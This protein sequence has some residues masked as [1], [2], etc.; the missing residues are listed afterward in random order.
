MLTEK[1]K[2]YAFYII[3]LFLNPRL[4]LLP[5]QGIY[6]PVYIQFEWLKKYDI[7]TV[8]DV[9]AYHGHVSKSLSYLFPQAKIYAFE[10]VAENYKILTKTLSGKNLALNQIALSGGV[11]KSTFYKNKYAP[12]SSMLPM[13]EKYKV[14]YPFLATATKT[15]VKT[16][17]LDSYFEKI[18]LQKKI[19]LKIDTQGT[20]YLILRGGEKILKNVFIIHIETSFDAMYKNQGTFKDITEYLTKLGFNYMGETRESQFYPIFG[21]K[22]SENSIFINKNFGV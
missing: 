2:N 19:L 6:L 1:I 15:K 5:C 10:P 14:I 9:G 3:Y 7:H 12:A 22:S 16:T 17:T 13:E 21:I 8:I 20:E 11:G 18:K 4:L